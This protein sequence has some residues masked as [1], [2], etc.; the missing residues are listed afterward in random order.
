[1]AKALTTT[2]SSVTVYNLVTNEVDTGGST[3][4]QCADIIADGTANYT[5]PEE[6]REFVI[7]NQIDWTNDVGSSRPTIDANAGASSVGV[8]NI[9][10]VLRIPDRT[11]VHEL[12][13]G[14]P[15]ATVCAHTITGSTGSGCLLNFAATAYKSASHS[16][17][18]TDLDGFGTLAV[19]KSTGAIASLPTVSAST[20]WTASKKVATLSNATQPCWFPYGGFVEMQFSAGASTSGITADG[21]FTGALEIQALCTHIPE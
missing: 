14:C 11:I 16:S 3:N 4:T 15:T 13:L 9:F 17:V 10:Q 5:T 21:A 12:V 1:M 7:R 20:P 8:A 6:L 19:T 18:V 2:R